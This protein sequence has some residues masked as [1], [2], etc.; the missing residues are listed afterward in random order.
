[1]TLTLTSSLDSFIERLLDCLCRAADICLDHDVQILDAV[2]TCGIE[3]ILQL[4]DRVCLEALVLCLVAWRCSARVRAMRSSS[5]A[6]NSSPAS[7]TCV[8]TDEL[9]R[10]GGPCLLDVL[11]LVVN[12]RADA[13][14]CRAGNDDIARMERTV[15]HKDGGDGA[16]AL[17]QLCLDDEYPWRGG[18]GWPSAPCTSA[19]SRTFSSRS[20][21]A[22]AGHGGN[23]HADRVAAP[24]LGHELVVR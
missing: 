20:G 5:T 10:D 3:Q 12:H 21:D 4:A 16:A 8:K 14:D 6:P 1:M 15:L 23:G 13:A 19:T 24:L 2:L 7:G 11:A 22:H 18:W 17:I 9:D